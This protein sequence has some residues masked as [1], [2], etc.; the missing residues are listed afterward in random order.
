MDQWAEKVIVKAVT[1]KAVLIEYETIEV[2]IADELIHVDSE[3][4]R[5][6][7][8]GEEGLLVIPNWLAEKKGLP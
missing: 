3:I 8:P 1:D 5:K 2:W 7:D 4:W 6:S